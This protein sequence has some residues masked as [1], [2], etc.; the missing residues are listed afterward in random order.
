MALA[1]TDRIADYLDALR[2]LAPLVAEH[3]HAFAA[4]AD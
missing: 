2:R 4:S 3:R 1:D